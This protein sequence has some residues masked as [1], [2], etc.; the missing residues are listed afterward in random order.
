MVKK[1]GERCALHLRQTPAQVLAASFRDM[2]G[3]TAAS[4]LGEIVVVV[5]VFEARDPNGAGLA[6]NLATAGLD[7]SLGG[8]PDA[9]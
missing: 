3:L 2:L 5:H 9:V 8:H 7:R 6:F 1:T 4:Q